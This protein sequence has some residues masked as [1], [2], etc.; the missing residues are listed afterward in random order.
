MASMALFD[1]SIAGSRY[2]VRV[3]LGCAHGVAGWAD[4]KAQGIGGQDDSPKE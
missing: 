1:R 3:A 2:G 4:A